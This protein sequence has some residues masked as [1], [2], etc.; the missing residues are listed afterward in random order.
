[1]GK[2]G[3]SVLSAVQPDHA[4]NLLRLKS[5]HQEEVGEHPGVVLESSLR[6]SPDLRMVLGQAED[7]TEVR[8]RILTATEVGRPPERATERRQWIAHAGRDRPR[9]ARHRVVASLEQLQRAV[10]PL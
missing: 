3:V 8:A 7:G 4:A 5:A 6:Y 2:R 9:E 1:V 10:Q